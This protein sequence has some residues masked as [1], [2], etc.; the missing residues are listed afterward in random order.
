MSKIAGKSIYIDNIE[1]YDNAVTIAE[2][3]WEEHFENNGSFPRGWTT[4]QVS[5]DVAWS[6]QMSGAT[7]SDPDA[8]GRECGK[9]DDTCFGFR[10]GGRAC[11]AFLA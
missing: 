10:F 4:E 5:G 1:V 9:V 8:L 11:L 7:P 3:P 6:I 2:F